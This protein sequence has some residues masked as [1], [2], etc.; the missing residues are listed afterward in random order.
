MSKKPLRDN[1]G[2]QN[3]LINSRDIALNYVWVNREP[4]ISGVDD[5][6]CGVPLHH[7]DRAITNAR[8]YRETPVSIWLDNDLLDDASLHMVASHVY[9]QDVKNI[10]IRNLRDIPS[11][12]ENADLFDWQRS[13]ANLDDYNGISKDD[14][15]NIWG[16]VDLARLLA[17]RHALD[18]GAQYALYADFDNDDVS[19]NGPE[20]LDIL[21]KHNMV[22][23]VTTSNGK[24]EIFENSYFAFGQQRS[25]IRF[26]DRMIDSTIEDVSKGV[27]GYG[28][29][30]MAIFN[31][32]L[33][34]GIEDEMVEL[35]YPAVV[36]PMGYKIPQPKLYVDEGINA[37]S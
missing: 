7:I 33:E 25:D 29:Y 8:Y 14:K 18:E 12:R 37:P 16:R 4:Y 31:Y 15:H 20:M 17:V 9:I 2:A 11:Y 23:G 27:N 32:A 6:L 21:K 30:Y 10:R 22:F 5:A 13:S 3:A 36:H 19:L 1:F 24:R 26:L 35:G 28:A 34:H